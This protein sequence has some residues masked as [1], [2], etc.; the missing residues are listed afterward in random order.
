MI[1]STIQTILVVIIVTSAVV[2]SV[3]RIFFDDKGGCG[4]GDG[5]CTCEDDK[6]CKGCQLAEQCSKK[7]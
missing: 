1:N 3:K 7:K 4:C 5:A 2:W 6:K